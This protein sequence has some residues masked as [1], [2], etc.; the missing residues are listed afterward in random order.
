VSDELE[1]IG[2][3]I[4]LEDGV[5]EGMRRISRDMALFSRQ[6]ELTAAQMSRVARLHLGAYLPPQPERP[7]RAA[8][9]TIPAPRNAQT[10]PATEAPRAPRQDAPASA[11]ATAAAHPGPVKRNSDSAAVALRPS[12]VA[13]STTTAVPR[14]IAVLQQAAPPQHSMPAAPP[15]PTQPRAK[16][17]PVSPG[18]PSP[19]SIAQPAAPVATRPT[20]PLDQPS[21]RPRIQVA[22]SS[23]VSPAAPLARPIASPAAET[24]AAKTTPLHGP[25]PAPL[26]PDARP[27][28]T[29]VI[30]PAR[31]A[32]ASSPASTPS[33]A[34]P[35][36]ANTAPNLVIVRRP[37]KAQSSAP[38]A[39]PARPTSP[40]QTVL[41]PQ[42][43]GAAVRDTVPPARV[44]PSP[45]VPTTSDRGPSVVPPSPASPAQ[46][47]PTRTS[48]PATPAAPAR[49]EQPP[50][51]A[52]AQMASVEGD[53]LLDGAQVGRWIST[54]MAR[55]AGR[56]PTAARGFNARMTPAWPGFPL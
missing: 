44:T 40:A 51:P 38:S 12:A 18:R 53:V 7:R 31:V 8:P 35:P 9:V 11:P 26:P 34:P 3:S 43:T 15:V 50:A 1:S 41:P 16:P 2:I 54:A 21:V 56:P 47:S 33:A 48:H 20:R 17:V 36:L 6:T 55:E 22:L 52:Q 19:A 28:A 46:Q 39:A 25:S 13:S 14:A 5:A 30:L 24:A 37:A 49:N 4:V 29:A 27:S 45:R 32:S 42:A 10:I 23:P